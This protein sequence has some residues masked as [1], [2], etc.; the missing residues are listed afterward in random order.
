MPPMGIEYVKVV[1]PIEVKTASLMIV[2]VSFDIV[3]QKIP[4]HV[5]RI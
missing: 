1:L 4:W 5:F 3:K 2:I